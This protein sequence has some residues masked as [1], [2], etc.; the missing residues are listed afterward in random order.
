MSGFRDSRPFRFVGQ[1]KRFP[2]SL[3]ADS[4]PEKRTPD[5]RLFYFSLLIPN[6]WPPFHCFRTDQYGGRRHVKALH[7]SVRFLEFALSWALVG[8]C[9]FKGYKF[10]KNDTKCIVKVYIS[11]MIIYRISQLYLQNEYTYT[12]RCNKQGNLT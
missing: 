11:H 1:G 9:G 4:I 12:K 2:F 10:Y 6:P 3:S 8:S 7:K 5:C